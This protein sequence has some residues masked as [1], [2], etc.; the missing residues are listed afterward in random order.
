[1][2]AVEPVRF[3]TENGVTLEGIRFE[4]D[5]PP[6]A[7]AVICH[8]HP[9]HGG[10]K[11]HPLLWQ[12]RI[13]LVR[14]G[15]VVLA[16]NFRGVMG[17]QGT[18]GGGEAEVADVRAAVGTVRASTE[19]PTLAVGWSFGAHVAL[20]TALLDD[21]IAALALVGFP[22]SD[23]RLALPAL[24][25]KEVLATF[26]RPVL[27]LSGAEDGYSPT[28]EVLALGGTLPNAS[29]EIMPSTDHYFGRREREA[30]A[31][32]GAFAERAV[33]GDRSS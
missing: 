31:L 6:R 20:R 26:D 14:R 1:L 4:P 2:R 16:F 30:A 21:R 24:P 7:S 17:S 29:I 28:E 18:Y 22:L 27:L 9:L 3:E 33:F 5:A 32:I 12:T 15:F 8:A 13:D 11:D 23:R 25:P 19:G 10:S